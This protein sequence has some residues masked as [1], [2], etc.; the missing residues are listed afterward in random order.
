MLVFWSAPTAGIV[1]LV[2]AL[3][4]AAVA[5]IGALA[6]AGGQAGTGVTS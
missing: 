3:V 5:V 1:L 4:V 2:A 6:S